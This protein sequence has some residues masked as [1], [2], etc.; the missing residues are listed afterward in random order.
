LWKEKEIRIKEASVPG[1][2]GIS[3]TSKN[4]PVF[5]KKPGKDQQ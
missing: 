1:I 5:M 4:R 3:R 2:S